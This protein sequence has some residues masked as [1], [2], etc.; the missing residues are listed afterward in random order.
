M[1]ES[2]IEIKEINYSLLIFP[3][4]S[5][6]GGAWQG[7]YI[8]DGYHWGYV[9]SNALD[10]LEGKMPYKEIFLEYGIVMSLIHAITLF[11]FKKNVAY[12]K[13]VIFFTCSPIGH[14]C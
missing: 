9:F 11:C 2:K 14:S 8:Y 3:I 5:L 7:Q 1:P 10:I 13:Y 4:I 12:S 6:I